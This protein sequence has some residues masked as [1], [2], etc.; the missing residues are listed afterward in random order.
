MII[1]ILFTP[2]IAQIIFKKTQIFFTQQVIIYKIIYLGM[3]P[4]KRNVYRNGV[5]RIVSFSLNPSFRYIAGFVISV[6]LLS[7]FVINELVISEVNCI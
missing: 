5:V 4:F 6:F 7:G 2:N 3:L 1:T